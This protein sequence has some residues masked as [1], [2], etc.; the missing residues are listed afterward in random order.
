MS[1][2]MNKFFEIFREISSIP[3]CSGNEEKIAG[4]IIK[5]A[6]SMGYGWNIDEAG[7]V[8]V[9]VDNNS[10][11]TVVLQNHMDMVCEKTPESSHDL[12][13]DPI[14][15]IREGDWLKADSTSLGA[16]NGAGIAISLLVAEDNTFEKPNLELL[17]TVDEERGLIGANNLGDKLLTG[18]YLINL[19]TEDEDE[20][21]IGCAGGRDT[22]VK[23]SVSFED[24][25]SENVFRLS[26][27][28][29][30]GGHSGLD[31]DKKR[32]NAIKILGS[33]LKNIHINGFKVK[34]IDIEG[35]TAHNAI[36]RNASA[37][38][39]TDASLND[40]KAI[41]ESTDNRCKKTFKELSN[42]ESITKTA[43]IKESADILQFINNV[44]HGVFSYMDSIPDKVETSSNLAVAAIRNGFVEFLVSQRGSDKPVLNKLTKEIEKSAENAGAEFTTG[45]EYPGWKPDHNSHLLQTAKQSYISVFGK[46]AKVD[47]VHA[48]LECGIIGSIYSGMEMISI[49]PTIHY[50]HSPDEKLKISSVENTISLLKEIFENLD[51]PH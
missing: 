26:I 51:T 50:A 33:V 39:E 11:N 21:I 2:T 37:V 42:P 10:N 32:D 14:K 22:L 45:N 25:V 35:G 48:G 4:W 19:D 6:E 43:S 24:S 17:F 27:S 41:A 47:A 7:N 8:C 31:I 36:P 16:D 46:E 3:R 28:G 40:L 49:G 12:T 30:K 23:K 15:I 20:I 29:L 13:K 5:R 38:F 1:Q 9:K 34:I 18:K 44:H